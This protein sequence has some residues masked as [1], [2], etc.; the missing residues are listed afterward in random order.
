MRQ[1]NAI[2]ILDNLLSKTL[3][4][5]TAIVIAIHVS[6]CKNLFIFSWRIP[7][8]WW[9]E[10]FG[11]IFYQEHPERDGW[12]LTEL[13]SLGIHSKEQKKDKQKL[14]TCIKQIFIS[15]YK[16]VYSNKKNI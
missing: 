6:A 15:T 10:L 4:T 7:W 1:Y 12:W 9:C 3:G 5:I 11:D 8:E 2:I 14:V 13:E 16:Q